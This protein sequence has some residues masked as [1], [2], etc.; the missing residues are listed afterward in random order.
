MIEVKNLGLQRDDWILRGIDFQFLT[1]KSYG[2][3]GKSGEGK[4]TFLKLLAGLLDANEGEVLFEGLPL[5]GPAFK[6]IP[7]YDEIQLVNQDFALEP[8]HSVEQNIKEKI[9]SRHNEVQEDLIE[10][11]LELVELKG[12]RS[13][14]AHLLSGGEQQRLSIAR[15]L[16]CE[17]KVLLLDE[18]FVHLDQRL[19]RKILTYLNELKEVRELLIILV[20]HDGAEMMG[21]ANE[22]I[23][24]ENSRIERVC[25]ANEMYYSP[26]SKEQG[27]LMGELNFVFLNGEQVFFR[28]TSF[29]LE[30]PNLKVEFISFLDIGLTILN[31]FRT[32]NG[33]EIIL[34]ANKKMKEVTQVRISQ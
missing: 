26:T 29:T 4:T 21:F 17:P 20:S 34:S 6:L 10:E 18:P 30:K 3:I 22:V 23:H 1:G 9:L 24:I 16:A 5:I 7:G 15:A 28:P 33:E 14:K 32:E 8:Y 11:F 19:R 27:E 2:I 13:R 31:Y 12:I 25:S